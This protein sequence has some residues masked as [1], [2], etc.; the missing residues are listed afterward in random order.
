MSSL[1][2]NGRVWVWGERMATGS[3]ADWIHVVDGRGSARGDVSSWC[4]GAVHAVGN[5]PRPLVNDATAKHDLE[6]AY[7]YPGLQDAHIH[8]FYTGKVINQRLTTRYAI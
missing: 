8:V 1:L 7:V 2:F 3:Y 6:G 4:L 5:N